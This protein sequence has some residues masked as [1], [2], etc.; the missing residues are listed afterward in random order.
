ML[1]RRFLGTGAAAI[2]LVT[3]VAV[4]VVAQDQD[5]S[6]KRIAFSNNY[7]ANSWRQAMLKS[8]TSQ[9]RPGRRRWRRRRGRRAHDGA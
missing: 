8:W 3:A 1:K 9:R 7:A 6:D 2:L 4:P 5:T